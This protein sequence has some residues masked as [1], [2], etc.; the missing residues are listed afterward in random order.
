MLFFSLIL[1]LVLAVAQP[2]TF[3]GTT[4][5]PDVTGGDFDHFA[6]NLRDNRLYVSAEV[7]QSI[8]VF[9]LKT[10]EHIGSAENVVKDPHTLVYLPDKN[11][12]LVA[13]GDGSIKVLDGADL[14]LIA[15]IP[16]PGDPDAALYDSTTRT[17][18][19]GEGLKR[20][21]RQF[22]YLSAISIDT[23]RELWIMRIEC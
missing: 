23:R 12:L 9:D 6:V 2:L 13:D 1:A 8:E 19:A 15:R 17:L 22:S 10:N 7:H 14:H 20:Q 16:L 21:H 11:E 3:L 5:I 18:Y 4:P